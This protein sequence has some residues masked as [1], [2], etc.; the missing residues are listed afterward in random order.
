M[1][2]APRYIP[3]YT[4]ADYQQWD[5][6]WELWQG[7]PVAM[8]PSPGGPH[9]RCSLRLARALLEAVEAGGCRAEVLQEID[10]IIS[11]DTVVR[12]DVVVICGEVPKKY[13]TQPPA[14]VAEILSP[15]TADRDRNEKLR[16]FEDQG[17]NYYLILD[18]EHGAVE[19][20]ELDEAGRL[21]PAAVRDPHQFTI[22]G[23]CHLTLDT[24]TV[25]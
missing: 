2:G 14:I 17:V 20:F 5:G 9:Q 3:H 7:I 25:F 21:M 22:C 24:G 23:D 15:S 12:P 16:L 8:A 18:P 4:V 1:S 6:D 11:D 10:W 13:L 19:C